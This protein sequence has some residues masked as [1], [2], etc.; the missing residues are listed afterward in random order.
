[1]FP[2][3]TCATIASSM[4]FILCLVSSATLKSTCHLEDRATLL[5][6]MGA[7]ICR[8]GSKGPALFQIAWKSQE[9]KLHGTAVQ[10]AWS[11]KTF[12]RL[13]S[14]DIK[15]GRNVSILQTRTKQDMPT[16]IVVVEQMMSSAG[17]RR[18]LRH[19]RRSM[20]PSG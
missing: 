4:R 14:A 1:M 9:A 8:R 12:P 15:R 13:A 18:P 2:L 20:L 3:S 11:L 16:Q 10:T 7:M 5:V 17:W 19:Q 6:H